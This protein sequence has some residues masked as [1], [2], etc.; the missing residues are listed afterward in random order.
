MGIRIFSEQWVPQREMFMFRCSTVSATWTFCV[1]QRALEELDDDAYFDRGGIFDAFRP[2]IYRVARRRIESG[3]PVG[4]HAI[5]AREIREVGWQMQ[6]A[7]AKGEPH[8]F[9]GRSGVSA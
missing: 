7:G 5:S 8:R 1:D 2:K 3:D 4:Q 6:D 9:L